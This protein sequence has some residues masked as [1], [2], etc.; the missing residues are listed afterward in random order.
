M[1]LTSQDARAIE[2]LMEE[3]LTFQAATMIAAQ[4]KWSPE[5][6]A[7]ANV[8]CDM[9]FDKIPITAES[10]FLKCRNKDVLLTYMDVV[11]SRDKRKELERS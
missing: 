2:V 1:T 11:I 9:K 8:I 3:E 7:L 5:G 6:L 10:L 4:R